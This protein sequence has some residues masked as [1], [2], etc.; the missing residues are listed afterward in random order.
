[1]IQKKIYLDFYNHNINSLRVKQ[2]DSGRTVEIVCT[3]S[4]K[5][6]FL[7]PDVVRAYVLFNKKDG[8]FSFKE[9]TITEDGTVLIEF[10][11]PM[12]SVVGKQ[13]ME[14]LIVKSEGLNVENLSGVACYE[15]FG[16]NVISS[17]PLYV[18]VIG[19]VIDSSEITS[20]SEFD[21]L[22]NSLIR[23]SETENQIKA[24]NAQFDV[25]ENARK[26]AELKR[27]DNITGEAYRIANEIKRQDDITGEVYRQN[28]E[29]VRQDAEFIRDY[30]ETARKEAEIKRQDD[31]TGE[32]YRIANEV[33]RQAAELNRQTTF[34][35]NEADRI[36]T[37]E[38]NESNRTTTFNNQMAE[39]TSQVSDVTNEANAVI[40][41][42]N[43]A[44]ESG[45]IYQAEK[46]T[47]NGVATL[48]ENG[49]VPSGQLPIVNTLES[50]LASV[51]HIFDAQ[52]L[53]V[54]LQSLHVVHTGTEKPSNELGKDGDIYMKIIADD[55]EETPV[56]QGGE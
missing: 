8:T 36:S 20:L 33:A 6:Y 45:G 24:V 52:S 39:Y 35:A 56:E 25:N 53:A 1:M 2:N 14:I 42:V 43:E 26:E 50:A 51:G 40:E 29:S 38:L 21:A 3:D 54:L 49:I 7:D 9:G 28:N 17:M 44:V 11:S 23:L 34:E 27:Q 5:K 13:S 15:D 31:I 41:R 46:G 48:D 55:T 47:A 22:T 19:S 16:A 37:F 10:T 30:N 4:G 18:T 32:A 12:I